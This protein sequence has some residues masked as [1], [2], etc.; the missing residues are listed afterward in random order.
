MME[1]KHSIRDYD[2]AQMGFVIPLDVQIRNE[3]NQN[4]FKFADDHKCS[5]ATNENPTPL[6]KLIVD[7]DIKT[8]T[9]YYTQTLE[10][11]D[12]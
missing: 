3:L 4:G 5:S 6:G 9:T 10:D 7:H 12:E 11:D 2:M 1:V 8:Q